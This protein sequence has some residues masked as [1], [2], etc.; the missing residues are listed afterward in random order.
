ML[1]TTVN[2]DPVHPIGIGTW[3]IASRA[4]RELPEGHYRNVEAVRGNEAAEI[5]GIRYSLELGQN[6]IDCAELYGSS[7][8]MKLSVK[9]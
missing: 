1:L 8:P 7:T 4:N 5:E 3:D 6:H 2:G 9:Q